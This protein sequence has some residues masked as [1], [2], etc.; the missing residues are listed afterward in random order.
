MTV[1]IDEVALWMRSNRLQLNTGKTEVLWCAS[2]RRQHQI[3]PD[4]VRIGDNVVLP[5]TTV[6]NLGIYFDSDA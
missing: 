3:P 2:S 6:R 5:V 1:C 4:P